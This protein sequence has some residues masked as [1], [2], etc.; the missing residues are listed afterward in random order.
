MA[1]LDDIVSFLDTELR[2]KEVPD[3]P[4]AMNGLQ[5]EGRQAVKRVAVAVDASLPV[6]RKAI[7]SG[8]NLLIVHH[9]MFW[10]GARMVTGATYEK[11]KIAMEA[12]L[13]IY[14]AHIPLDIHPV[15][16]NNAR[17]ASALELQGAEPFFEWKGILLGIRGRFEG[18]LNQL[19]RR[20]GEV[21]GEDP[22]VCS[23]GSGEAGVVGV[24]TGGA[25][26]EVVAVRE[27]GIDSFLTGE[28]P[29]WS[30]TEAEELGMNMIYGGHYL[31]ETG[32]VKAI[33]DV[34]SEKFGLEA[35][36][37]DHPTGI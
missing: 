21:L 36:F 6:V 11:F 25:G 8:A 31:T 10:N 19:V 4:G 34:L 9:G 13:A 23:A 32:G 3:Y 35:G 12:G 37:I 16:G 18:S 5:M 27:S 28:G 26:S 14:S 22:H 29:H 1:T 7:E 33:A 20:V 30:Y 2:I 24:I 17:L 15:V